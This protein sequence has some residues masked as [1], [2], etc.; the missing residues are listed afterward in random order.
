[1]HAGAER[2]E[3]RP[4]QRRALADLAASTSRRVILVLPTGGGKTE[5][6]AALF[7]DVV[8]GGGRGLF[9]THRLELVDQAA[10]RIAKYGTRVGVIQGATDPDPSAPVQV[11]SVQTLARRQHPP[12]DLVI[13]DEAHHAVAGSFAD[14]I[15]AYPDARHI[16]LTATPYRLDGRGLGTLFEEIVVASHP[17]ELVELGYLVPPR[18]YT[19]PPPDLTGIRKSMGDYATGQLSERMTE[20]AGDV[21]ATWQ[22]RASDRKTVV[23]GVDIAHSMALADRFAASGI[24]AE[25]FD[26]GDDREAR[27]ATLER[28]RSGA[29]AVLSNCSLISEGFDLPEIGCVVMARPTQSRAL[30]K[31]QAGR[32]MRPA[33]GKVDC[34][35]LDNAGNFGRHGDPMDVE[36]YTLEDGVKV[37]RPTPTKQCKM[38]FAVVPASAA[39]C[40]YCGFAPPV[41]IREVRETHEDLVEVSEIQARYLAMGPDERLALYRKLVVDCEA[42]GYKPGWVAY[43]YK[44]KFGIWP[45]PE[46]MARAEAGTS[47]PIDALAKWLEMADSRG[48]KR[49]WASHRFKTMYGRWPSRVEVASASR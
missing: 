18:I 25:H 36:S 49:G 32:A 7:A 14:V 37:D 28:F 16:G 5:I 34:I 39:K 9:L 12:A 17:R 31:Q 19:A 29:T 40:P 47:K 38:C 21:V 1:M 20:L 8:A 6:A 15:A 3:L 41:Q 2:L 10:A 4:Y 35:L 46:V 24:A 33:D 26:G 44:S 23:F 11:A 48:W 43:R 45:E 22:K 30:Y 27:K 13:T 42:M